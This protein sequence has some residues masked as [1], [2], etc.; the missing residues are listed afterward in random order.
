[1]GMDEKQ[2]L[3]KKTGKASKLNGTY[4]Y[5]LVY[6]DKANIWVKNIQGLL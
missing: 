1:V 2:S 3:Q 4:Y 6:T 5:L